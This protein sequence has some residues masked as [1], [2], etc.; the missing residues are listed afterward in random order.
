MAPVDAQPSVDV[1][2]AAPVTPSAASAGERGAIEGAAPASASLESAPDAADQTVSSAPPTAALS[3]SELGASASPPAA[4]LPPEPV[5]ITVVG[6]RLSST[7]GSAHVI[8]SRQLERFEYDDPTA[9]LLSVPGL[10]VRGEDGM[11]LRPNISLRG[12]NP[13]RSKKITLLED[14]VLFGPAPYSAPAAYYFPVFTRMTKVKVVKGPA[15]IGQGP[16]TIAGAIDFITRDIPEDIAAAADVAVG[17]YGYGKAHVYAGGS[18]GRLGFLIEGVRLQNNGFKDLEDARGRRADTGFVRNEWMVKGAWVHERDEVRNELRLKL[19]YS[20]E[21]SN[22]SYLG[23]TDADFA[24]NPNRRY[25]VTQLDRMRNHRASIVATHVLDFG[26][27]FKL[28]TNVYRHDF[29]RVW[30]KVNAFADAS[31]FDVLTDPTSGRHP[32]YINVL[33]GRQPSGTN[34]QILI[35]PNE[36]GFIS[37]GIETRLLA[38]AT[39]G[40]IEH[41]LE[42]GARYHHDFIDRRHSQNGFSVDGDVLVPDGKPTEV[43]AFNKEE[44][45]AVALHLQY[46]GSWKGLTLTPGIRIELMRSQSK[47]RLAQTEQ[48][49]FNHGVLPGVG[50]YY[51]IWRGLGVLGGVYKGFSPPPPGSA[52]GIKP[53]SS[54]NYEA[55][56]RYSDRLRKLEGI[57]F[58]NDYEN[59]TDVCTFSSGCSDSTVDQQFDA[60]AARTYGMEV[61]GDYSVPIR[62][63]KLP[64]LVA[65]TWTKSQFENTFQSE[66]PIWGDVQKGDYLP[67]V[68]RHQVRVQAGVEHA[69]AGAN[70]AVTYVG[71]MREVPG[72][73]SY[74]DTLATDATTVVDL[75]GFAKIWGPFSLYANIQN[76]FDAQYIVSRR[77][78]GARPN[79]PRWAHVGIKATY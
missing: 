19:T 69:R 40:A 79:A 56:A 66:D 60:G 26:A 6:T 27:R 61:S 35:G 67:Y 50:A 72:R 58:Y 14:G 4:E 42:A 54:I 34:G 73:A 63:Y 55:G 32:A 2:P 39:T 37:E 17:Q 16:Q 41:R 59:L 77:P 75:A 49:Q 11:G 30:R 29:Q 57:F 18:A 36:R 22:E 78:F 24:D 38:S 52:D 47:D 46:A 44:T 21:T 33:N 51:A 68:P 12:V 43:T 1:A 13:D 74:D 65:Y 64:L 15:A 53:E 23:L 48:S 5:E 28:T 62:A 9:A 7:A 45:H 70:V 76:L 20:D 31:L 25:A 10:N 71:R 8:S 3:P